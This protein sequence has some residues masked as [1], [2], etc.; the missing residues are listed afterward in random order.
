[1]TEPLRLRRVRARLAGLVA[2]V[3]LTLTIAGPA[4]AAPALASPAAPPAPPTSWQQFGYQPAKCNHATNADAVDGSPL[5]RC[6]ALGLATKDGRLVQQVSEPPSTAL[7]PAEIQSAYK[8]PD[9]GAGRTVAIVDAFGYDAAEADL[10]VFRAHYGLPP[11]TSANG[12]FR[13]VDQNGGTKY[14][15]QDEGWSIET[16]LD[17]D[18]V[19]S[20]C[21]KCDILLVQADDNSSANLGAAVDTAAR[22]GATGISNSYGIA[23]E[24][25]WQ[26]QYDAH[27]DHPGIAVTV[28]SGDYGNVQSFPATNPNVVAVGGTKLTRD[29]SA[30]GWKETAWSDAGSGCSLYEP[31]PDYQAGVDTACADKRAT[32]DISAVADP[33]T[34]LAVYNTLGQDGWAQWGGTSL[35]APLVAAMYALAGGPVPGTYPVTYPYRDDKAAHLFDVTE[36][37]N[38]RCGDQRCNARPGWDGPTGLGSPNGVAALTLGDYGLITGTVTGGKKHEILV[39]ATVSVADSTGATFQVVTDAAGRYTLAVPVGTHDV[40]AAKFGYQNQTLPGVSV[41]THA[42]V[43]G[44]FALTPIASRGLTGTVTDASGH[45]WPV[46]A[47]ISIDGYPNGPVFTDPFTGRYQVDLPVDAAYT[48][49][50]S[51]VDMPGYVTS[52]LTATIDPQPTGRPSDVQLDVPLQADPALCTAPGYAYRYHGANADFEGWGAT[53]HSGWQVT[54]DA[55]TGKTWTFNDPGGKGNLTGGSGD[56]AIID[57][58]YHPGQQDTSLISPAVDLSGEANPVIGFDTDYDAWGEQT[59]DVYLSLDSGDTW[60]SVWHASTKNVRGHVEIPLPQAAGKSGV[61]VRLRYQ[62]KYDNWWQLDNVF[63]GSRSCDAIPG[64]LVTGFVRDDNTGGPVIGATVTSGTDSAAIAISQATA[65]DAQLADGFYWLFV[66][67]TGSAPMTVTGR[68]YADSTAS[69]RVEDDRVVRRDWRLAAGHLTVH[70]TKLSISTAPG[71]ATS[72]QV[73][74]TND[75]TRPLHVSLVEQDRG[76]TP[77]GGKHQPAGPQAP[78]MRVKTETSVAAMRGAARPATAVA[79]QATTGGTAWTNLPDYP[80]LIMDNLVADND[81][82]VYSVGGTGDEAVTAKGH[83]YDPQAKAWKPIADLPEPREAPVGAFV[84]GRLLV[85]GGWST[86]GITSTT[87]SY[88]PG[89]NSWSRKADLPITMSAGAAASV[90]GKLYVVGGCTTD[91]CIPASKGTFRYDSGSDTWTRLA[92]YP[93]SV[94]F[95]ACAPAGDGLVCAGGIDPS[96]GWSG[97]PTNTTYQYFPDSDTWVR[98]AYMPYYTWGMA[99]AGMGGKL[100]VIGG[101][102]S[103]SI[104]NQA[105][106]FDP[107]TGTWSA[108]PNANNAQYRGGAA[109]GLYQVGGSSY[110]FNATPLVQQLSGYDSCLHG[111]DVGWLS[112]DRT[113]L[114]V[115][116]GRSVTVTVAVDAPA[117]AGLG[118]YDGRLAITTD[119]PYPT[120]P[121]RVAMTLR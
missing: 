32:A 17:L 28:S 121:I 92:D 35:S 95:L 96:K 15:R 119:T 106:E 77:A 38:G 3:T 98:V 70:Q 85:V 101:V 79:P 46:Y 90:N 20:A 13:K 94:A 58:W 12:C 30:R 82:T 61:Q 22:L 42:T 54:D 93:E 105:V 49:H 57:G 81:G 25:R 23:G 104:T 114:T 91:G 78:L 59:A 18:A 14:P 87:Y 67:A 37:S 65:D 62:G 44:T 40:V 56:F 102:V 53:P 4:S 83:A 72:R 21:P 89:S 8:L 48:L 45:G 112:V 51:P 64:G 103:G 111:S 55:G 97:E 19:S 74:L 7:G 84:N 88:D 5:A 100:Q 36:G 16:A 39:G 117:V 10:A 108:L 43:D 24:N 63:V 71:R 76:Y 60:T 9:G 68:N 50:V 2:L 69:V 109:C 120:E 80:A 115:P 1:M 118:E 41:A 11:C 86:V 33:E 52:T 29:S 110:S 34:G 47:R 107:A 66:P 26:S 75:G 116:A 27:Y 73:R 113:Q 99:Y 31:R 6:F